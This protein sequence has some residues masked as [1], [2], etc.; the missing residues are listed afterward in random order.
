MAPTAA[1]SEMS[2]QCSHE[3]ILKCAVIEQALNAN[4][5]DLRPRSIIA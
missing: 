2:Y 5:L 4:L 1:L 3:Y